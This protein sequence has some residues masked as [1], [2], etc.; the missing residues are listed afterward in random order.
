MFFRLGTLEI[1]EGAAIGSWNIFYADRRYREIA[2]AAGTLLMDA[3]SFITSRHF[4]D[5]S[6]TVHLGAYAAF[7]GHHST[8]ET[9]DLDHTTNRCYARRV[10]IGERAGVLTNCVLAPG[11]EL[12]AR[13]MLA[14]HSLLVGPDAGDRR[15][16]GIYAGSPAR[17]VLPVSPTPG[18]WFERAHS[19][20]I[21]LSG[22]G[23]LTRFR[24]STPREP[25][26]APDEYPARE[27]RMRKVRNFASAIGG[28]QMRLVEVVVW[29]LPAGR[30]KNF[31]LR[32]FGHT[33]SKSAR[34]A[35]VLAMNVKRAEI[36]ESCSI[37]PLNLFRSITLLRMGDDS[38]IGSLNTVSAS[39]LFREVAADAGSLLM[40]NG[41][42]ITNR[43]Y[44]DCSGVVHLGEFA[45]FWGQRTT[46][47]THEIDYTVNKQTVGRVSIGARSAVLTCCVVL[48]GAVLPAHSMLAAH[49]TLVRAKNLP[50]PPGMY[51]GTPA[52]HLFDLPA[53]VGTW[54]ERA[55]TETTEL[56]V[57]GPLGGIQYSDERATDPSGQPAIRPRK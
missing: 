32:R 2:T 4:F 17:M 51:G 12:P 33:V 25:T 30:F 5:C 47:L 36:G 1:R 35:P 44:L 7:G 31:M 45:G 40:D 29:L 8:V 57:D 43:H 22:E 11:S 39:P 50:L 13:S 23:E 34:I 26:T 38:S 20:T 54:F 15:E 24:P 52:R 46:L 37:G 27:H 14:A 9:R 3:G 56:R 16:S 21:A 18:S 28:R 49:S 55:V 48:K 10:A 19:D 41:S 53:G 42:F 6:G